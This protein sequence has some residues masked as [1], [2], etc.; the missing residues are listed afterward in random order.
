MYLILLYTKPYLHFGSSVR[1][2][3]PYNCCTHSSGS[4]LVYENPFAISAED[5][6]LKIHILVLRITSFYS[7]ITCIRKVHSFILTTF[8]GPSAFN[9]MGGHQRLGG[10]LYFHLQGRKC[11]LM[12]HMIVKFCE[13][14][15]P[16]NLKNFR[17]TF[18]FLLNDRDT[19]AL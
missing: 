14:V 11:F 19:Y 15:G 8:S 6:M 10:T 18:L 12:R 4:I 9:W 1:T 17:A 16:Q 7:L 5:D 2:K 13:A 3:T